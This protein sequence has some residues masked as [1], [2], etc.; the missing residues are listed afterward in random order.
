M[1]R[2]MDRRFDLIGPS[3]T[4]HACWATTAAKAH[5]GGR[6]EGIPVNA[7]EDVNQLGFAKEHAPR[8]PLPQGAPPQSR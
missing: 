7:F 3:R 8:T 1:H 6:K 5:V 4:I 2:N